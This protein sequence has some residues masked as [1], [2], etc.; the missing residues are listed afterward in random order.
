MAEPPF[1]GVC[2]YPEHWDE[3]RWA[4]DAARMRECGL[5]QVRIGEFAWSRI[6][7]TPGQ[8]EWDWLDRAINTL[9]GV[10]LEIM[11]GT[12]TATPP[13]WLV[14]A[15]PDIL[16]S[17]AHGRPRKFGSRRHYCF[18]SE[19]YRRE[20]RR[21]TEAVAARYGE[22][23]G[24]TAWQTDN[25]YGCHDTVRSYSPAA[26][27]AFRKWL[28][29]RYVEIAAL[30]SAWGTVFWS[31]EYRSF[32]E[33]DLPAMAVTE[34]NP[35]QLLDF[36]RFSSDQVVSFNRMQVE[37]LRRHSPGRSIHHNFM[38]FFF[39]F[40]H[41]AL[42]GDLD[43]AGWD[44]YP[45]GFLD[46]APFDANDKAR[47][48]RQGHP[49]I[50]AFHHDLYRAC[51]RGRWCVLEQQPGPV[52][53][54][55]N[56][57]APLPGM[58]RLWSLEAF[59]H[60][61]SNVNYFRWRQAPFAQ[62]QM[63]AGLERVDGAPAPA[64]GEPQQ[65][66]RELAAIEAPRVSARAKTAIL[67]SYDAHWLF[68]AQ[69]QGAGWRYAAIVFEWYSALR[70]FGLDVDFVSTQS[71]V[72]GYALLIVP[73]LPVIEDDFLARVRDCGA[74]TLFGPRTGSKTKSL[75]IPENLAPGLLQA[76]VPLKVVRSQSFPEFHRVH[77]EIEGAPVSGRVWLDEIETELAPVV[78]SP[79]GGLLYRHG[80]FFY[81]AT[82]PD[83]MFLGGIVTL[84]TRAA[85][86]ETRL[87]P[88]DL[89][90]RSQGE[91]KFVVNYGPDRVTIPE[92]VAPPHA[93]FIIGARAI[94]PAGVAAWREK[95]V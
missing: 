46:L 68:E 78:D 38:G 55:P 94:E 17:D 12:P 14:D 9:A 13:K 85:G 27:R 19:T 71:S 73:S 67:F 47:Y 90:L 43:V 93:S 86:L 40:D 11:L 1:L 33:V 84:L 3:S 7:P 22:H 29:Q 56:N 80:D 57:P 52:N 8:F 70:R 62:E 42:S 58:V 39:S 44:S 79:D 10:G 72:D 65:V 83:P 41:F 34:Q 64:F 6:E 49:D 91:L 50:A 45:L 2:Y 92:S 23:P 75:Q 59:A 18:S 25:E 66:A 37:I 48:M 36:F 5:K 53:W 51:G 28:E 74:V 20:A 21:I 4:V 82:L 32:E 69:A 77:G 31:Q 15:H 61:A 26:E 76:L 87:L 16:A 89:R 30:N 95:K 54:A 60:G 35:S 63:H 88:A 81:L 24:V